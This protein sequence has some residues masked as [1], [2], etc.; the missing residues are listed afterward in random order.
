MCPG[1]G[2]PA[3]LGMVERLGHPYRGPATG[4]VARRALHLQVAVWRAGALL[5]LEGRAEQGGQREQDEAPHLD[6]LPWQLSH[7]P[8]TGR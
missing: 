3:D 6:S 1:K 5:T 8:E 4:D 7:F 2:E